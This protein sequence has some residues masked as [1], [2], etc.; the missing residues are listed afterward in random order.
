[1][2]DGFSIRISPRGSSALTGPTKL[3][4]SNL[5]FGVSDSDVTVSSQVV[6]FFL[7]KITSNVMWSMPLE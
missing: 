7:Y 4:V 3:L 1:M 6:F 2:F 5:E